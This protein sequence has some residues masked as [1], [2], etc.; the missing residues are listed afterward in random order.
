MDKEKSYEMKRVQGESGIDYHIRVTRKAF[1]PNTL[2][3]MHQNK[4]A[5]RD[6]FDFEFGFDTTR[7][8]AIALYLYLVT[9]LITLYLIKGLTFA[10]R[11]RKHI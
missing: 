2:F 8:Q 7:G 6:Y 11:R 10:I 9:K 3:T 1:N 5:K 4:E